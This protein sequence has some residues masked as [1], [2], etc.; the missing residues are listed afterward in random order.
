MQTHINS[1]QKWGNSLDL[2]QMMASS[3]YYII[4]FQLQQRERTHATKKR[5]LLRHKQ[6][7]RTKRN[8]DHQIA[9]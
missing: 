7:T 4:H 8:H 1:V 6:R 5:M 3:T 2:K 9:K